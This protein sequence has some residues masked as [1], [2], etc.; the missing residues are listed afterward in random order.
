MEGK[1]NNVHVSPAVLI[2]INHSQTEVPV[3]HQSLLPLKD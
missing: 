2:Q 3:I 1:G